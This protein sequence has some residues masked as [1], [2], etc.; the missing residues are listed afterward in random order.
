MS[1]HQ[2]PS[3]LCASALILALGGASCKGN[4][5]PVDQGQGDRIHPSDWTS[6]VFVPDADDTGWMADLPIYDC[7]GPP[8][9]WQDWAR[10]R[11]A[12]RA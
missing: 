8:E 5:A 3:A 6:E 12:G 1:I 9:G 4:G 2:A 10:S 11:K 7:P